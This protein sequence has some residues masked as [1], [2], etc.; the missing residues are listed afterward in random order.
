MIITGVILVAPWTLDVLTRRKSGSCFLHLPVYEGFFRPGK[1]VGKVAL[2]CL[3]LALRCLNLASP[4]DAIIV[5]RE[6]PI[7]FRIYLRIIMGFWVK[8][9]YVKD[10]PT[11]PLNLVQAIMDDEKLCNRLRR[12][13]RKHGWKLQPLIATPLV[14]D[15]AKKLNTEVAGTSEE[16]VRDLLIQR[17]N[18]KADFADWFRARGYNVAGVVCR[19]T[20]E[21]I[22][23][24]MRLFASRHSVIVREV[25][26]AG[27]LG[28][29]RYD[30]LKELE[31][32]IAGIHD[33]ESFT[34]IVG[35]YIHDLQH[36]SFVYEIADDGARES[37]SCLRQLKNSTESVGGVIPCPPIP[38]LDNARHPA[39]EYMTYLYEIGYRGIVDIDAGMSRDGKF[40]VFFESNARLVLTSV[41]MNIA[42]RFGERWKAHGSAVVHYDENP[43]LNGRPPSFW[44]LTWRAWRTSWRCR[45]RLEDMHARARVLIVSPPDAEQHGWFSFAAV[46]TSYEAAQAVREEFR[47]I[48]VG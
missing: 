8:I 19:G 27:G 36:I 35:H 3:K 46:G 48:L 7:W 31:E 4:G 21:I 25:V 24:A 1:A 9:Y 42:K 30:S 11:D 18:N 12:D 41:P 29:G 37:C 14:F 43:P 45:K 13:S 40:V 44:M 2:K 26:S 47:K 38:W 32:A 10:V 16:L 5:G 34:A 17:L 15:L 39:R 28:N 23:E 20:A 6:V 33:P 22:A